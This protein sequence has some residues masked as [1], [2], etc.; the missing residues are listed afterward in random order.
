MKMLVTISC[1]VRP[2]QVWLRENVWGH[3][4]VNL[5]WSVIPPTN[6]ALIVWICLQK[7]CLTHC[8]LSNMFTHH[9]RLHWWFS[10]WS[11]VYKSSVL[12][13][14]RDFPFSVSPGWKCYVSH[15]VCLPGR[16][17]RPPYC[18]PLEG[19]QQQCLWG[20]RHSD[21]L[22]GISRCQIGPLT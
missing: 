8:L 18:H 10:V 12:F 9:S 17:R 15:S 13:I 21:L 19:L 20:R 3:T 1:F 2:S 7:E 14:Q 11:S 4:S 22:E 6:S 16:C 5:H